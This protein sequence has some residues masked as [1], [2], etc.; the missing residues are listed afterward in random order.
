MYLDTVDI[1]ST[2]LWLYRRKTQLLTT[3]VVA[4]NKRAKMKRDKNFGVEIRYEGRIETR[5]DTVTAG[6]SVGL[7]GLDGFPGCF[8]LDVIY[9]FIC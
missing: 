4:I 3:H 7:S 9:L 5:G 8:K 6:S 2:D 1:L